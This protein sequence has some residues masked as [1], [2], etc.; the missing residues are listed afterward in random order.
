M[1]EVPWYAEGILTCSTAPSAG[2]FPECAGGA[3]E[4]HAH[5]QLR[6]SHNRTLEAVPRQKMGGLTNA[7]SMRLAGEEWRNHSC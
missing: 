5:N 1:C 2:S 3:Q 7:R 4:L 6:G